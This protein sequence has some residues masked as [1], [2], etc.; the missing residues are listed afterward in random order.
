LRVC[1]RCSNYHYVITENKVYCV[2]CNKKIGEIK[3]TDKAGE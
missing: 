1:P 2:E 3:D